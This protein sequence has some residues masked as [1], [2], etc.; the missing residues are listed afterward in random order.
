MSTTPDGGVRPSDLIQTASSSPTG[1]HVSQDVKLH[2]K[3]LDKI[4]IQK[5]LSLYKKYGFVLEHFF[6]AI[7][8]NYQNVPESDL[9]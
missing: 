8:K 1:R 5:V 7:C 4:E 2:I 3:A 6:S 9:Y